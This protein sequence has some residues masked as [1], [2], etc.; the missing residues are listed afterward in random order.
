MVTKGSSPRATDDRNWRP[1]TVVIDH[2]LGGFPAARNG[3]KGWAIRVSRNGSPTSMVYTNRC[4]GYA[5]RRVSIP[6]L[7]R[8]SR[9]GSR[10][11]RQHRDLGRSLRRRR[12]ARCKRDREKPCSGLLGLE[13]LFQP[14][15]RPLPRQG[16]V[17]MP[18]RSRR[19]S[20][21]NLGNHPI[22]RQEG[23]RSRRRP[24]ARPPRDFRCCRSLRFE[25]SLE[26]SWRVSPQS[27]GRRRSDR[28]E[29]Y[30]L[31]TNRTGF[32]IFRP[33]A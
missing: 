30:P 14:R 3:R 11:T 24:T 5:S 17:R 10:M 9:T 8:H 29:P 23:I 31:R 32:G 16:S 27:V 4:V 26:R 25:C 22:A 18:A 20:H 33:S 2:D 6:S 15:I 28:R 13:C 1:T 19:P 21:S 7:A 12:M